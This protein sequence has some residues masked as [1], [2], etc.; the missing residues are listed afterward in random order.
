[1]KT[2]QERFADEYRRPDAGIGQGSH[3]FFADMAGLETPS[4]RAHFLGGYLASR[5]LDVTLPEYDR[6]AMLEAAAMLRAIKS[7]IR[8][9]Q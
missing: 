7:V 9:G 3:R 4:A 8:D 2:Q 1:M 5:A 6:C